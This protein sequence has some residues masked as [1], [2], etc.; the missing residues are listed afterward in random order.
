MVELVE[1]LQK[2][3]RSTS[4]MTAYH[5]HCEKFKCH[6]EQDMEAQPCAVYAHG[7]HELADGIGHATD[8]SK[9]I[10]FTADSLAGCT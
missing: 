10:A 8:M 9:P 3:D 1:T 6:R 4:H 5:G 7:C 2:A